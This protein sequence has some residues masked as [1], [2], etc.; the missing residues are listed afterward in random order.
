MSD[1]EDGANVVALQQWGKDLSER[2]EFL[3][4]EIRIR[5]SELRRIQEQLSLLLRLLELNGGEVVA[6]Q[7]RGQEQ[8]RLASQAALNGKDLEDA[9]EALLRER[10]EPL[11]ISA[12]RA[13]LV[14]AGFPIPGRGDDANIIVRISKLP[15]RFTRTARGT[16]ALAD[17]G[18]P[19]MK[20]KRS[21]GRPRK[22]S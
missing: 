16:Y 21:S 7:S 11:H 14:E 9:V 22:T 3:E 10:N 1:P 17:W 12:I 18:L 4:S 19:E 6:M 2:A 13:A 5:T 15:N 20:S 8:G